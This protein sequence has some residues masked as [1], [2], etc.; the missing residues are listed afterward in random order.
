M[1][2]D[3]LPDPSSPF[4]RQVR[5]RLAGE[6]IIWFTSVGRD[7]TPQPN[8]VWF[9]WDG[10]SLLTYNTPRANRLVHI[11]RRPQVSLHLNTRNGGGILVVT[12][13]AEIVETEVPAD[14]HD[15]YM[16]KYADSMAQVSGSTEAFARTYSVPVRV[17]PENIRGW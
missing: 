16:A 15:G 13:T 17:R 11:R 12:G 4:G 7:G 9:L 1:P 14:Q 3:V 8:P 5:E 2:D 6:S 10:G